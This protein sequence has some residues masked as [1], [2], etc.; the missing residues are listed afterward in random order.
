MQL[1]VINSPFNEEQT[2]NLNRLL[3]TLTETQKIWLSGFLAAASPQV[4]SIAVLSPP[5][6][7]GQVSRTV[8]KTREVTILFGSE[9]GNCQAIAES[10]EQK[11]AGRGFKT[12]LSAMDTYKTKS[13]KSVQDILIVTATHG[14]GHPPDNAISFHEFLHG[15]KAPKLQDVRFSVLALGDISYEYFC[16]TG[17]DFDQ[18]LEELG[19]ERLYPRVDCD[20]DFDEAAETWIEGVLNVLG[21]TDPT[22]T[23]GQAGILQATTTASRESTF[24]RTNPFRAEVLENINL[25][26]QGSFKETRHLELSIEGSNLQFEP[27][28]SLGIF[29]ENDS[30]LVDQILEEMQWNPEEP[31]I[32][33]KQGESLFLREALLTRFEITVLTKP[34]LEKVAPFSSNS[35]LKSLL[36]PGRDSELRAYIDGRD[37]L[38]LL[39]DFGPWGIEPSQF[40][41]H[42]RKIPARLYSIASSYQANPDEVHLTIGTVRYHA[43]GRDRAG[44]CS[45][46]CAERV[47]PGDHLHVYVHRNPNFKMPSD[48]DAPVIMVGPGTGVAPFRSFLEER[49]EL[50]VKGRTWLFFGD[51]HFSSDFLY[52]VDWQRWLKEGVL[53]RMDVAFS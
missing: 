10:L 46:Q 4:T 44:V 31:V 17:K 41:Q 8:S 53:T 45:S 35:H 42:L 18:R 14:E 9:T 36:E 29:P 48:P 16:Q 19:G 7:Q 51:Q 6:E 50:G 30:L 33:S 25:N 15:R 32:V 43:H 49:E 39:K 34:L 1:Q 38:D 5:S 27:G 24:S 47:T 13:L 12:S 20:V 23:I 11:L 40:V 37:L 21:E 3:P 22:S 2:E 28:D 26:G 52:Q